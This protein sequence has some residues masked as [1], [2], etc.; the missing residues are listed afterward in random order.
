MIAEA[1]KV[2]NRLFYFAVPPTVFL[3]VATAIKASAV[4][5]SG[6][7]RLVVEKPFGHD[8]E[9]CEKVGDWAGQAGE[10]GFW[11]LCMPDFVCACLCSVCQLSVGLS[12]LFDE[13]HLYRIDHYLGKEMVQNLLVLRFGNEFLE[14]L[15]NRN[16][17]QC[18]LITF[19]EDFGTQGRGG[20]FDQ[21]GIIRDILQ[22]HLTQVGLLQTR[23][24]R[25]LDP[26]VP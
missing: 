26:A 20:Y 8:Y 2:S 22:N 4:S 5:P 7:T 9:S 18:V 11:L 12:S 13:S 23:H 15:W 16:H 25:H 17:I 24:L 21:S 19:K 6:W 14:P 1:S 3:D 10:G